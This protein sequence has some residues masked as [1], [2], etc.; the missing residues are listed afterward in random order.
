MKTTIETTIEPMRIIVASPIPVLAP[1]PRQT[2]LNAYK[3]GI[4]NQE[5]IR[6][7]AFHSQLR[8][9]NPYLLPKLVCPP[10]L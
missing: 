1:R 9:P 3:Y 7:I 10:R 8:F 2:I 5:M 6:A 4:D